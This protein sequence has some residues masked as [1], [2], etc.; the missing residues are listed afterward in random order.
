[1]RGMFRLAALLVLL[2]T[3]GLWWQ[4]GFDLG[5][6]KTSVL[7]MQQDPVTGIEAPV[8]EKAFVPGVDFVAGGALAAT[9]LFGSSFFCRRPARTPTATPPP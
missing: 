1:M 9:L 3:V 5:W 2:A 6:T 8:W 7:R 4:G